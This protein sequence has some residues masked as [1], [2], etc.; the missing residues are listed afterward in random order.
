VSLIC[1][2]AS[3]VGCV[4]DVRWA[5]Y[6]SSAIPAARRSHPGPQKCS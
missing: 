4:L 1:Q 5:Y 3:H 2:G 6:V